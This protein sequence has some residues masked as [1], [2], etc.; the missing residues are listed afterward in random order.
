MHYTSQDNKDSVESMQ[1]EAKR[2]NIQSDKEEDIQSCDRDIAIK[3]LNVNTMKLED[4][5]E[6]LKEVHRNHD[7]KVVSKVSDNVMLCSKGYLRKNS[8]EE[9][10]HEEEE[11]EYNTYDVEKHIHFWRTK[12]QNMKC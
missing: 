1:S 3:D 7:C 6:V 10:L 12:S 8:A 11:I 2:Q 9:E 4:I 5:E